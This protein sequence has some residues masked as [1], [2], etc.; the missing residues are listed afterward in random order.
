MFFSKLLLTELQAKSSLRWE[1]EGDDGAGSGR[2][3]YDKALP[4]FHSRGE[5]L[6]TA[7]FEPS[8]PC[9]ASVECLGEEEKKR[10]RKSRFS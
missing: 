6:A 2:A 10:E 5:A 7:N 8:E 3:A 9:D 4:R 1:D